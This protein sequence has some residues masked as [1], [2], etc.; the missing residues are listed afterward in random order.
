MY[1]SSFF[2][3]VEQAAGQADPT[4]TGPINFTAVFSEGIDLDTFT[5]DDV[6]TSGSTTPGTL[7]A[8]I[9][10]ISPNNGT[11]FNIEIVGMTGDGIVSASSRRMQSRI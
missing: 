10:E 8:T 9:L 1:T 6:D 4:S 3:T 7:T 2:V 5:P 11:T